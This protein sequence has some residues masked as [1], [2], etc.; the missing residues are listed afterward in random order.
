MVTKFIKDFKTELLKMNWKGGEIFAYK[1]TVENLDMED[2]CFDSTG[3][4]FCFLMLTFT[5]GRYYFS[6]F[7]FFATAP[8]TAKCKEFGFL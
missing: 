8:L 3:K 4:K 6:G 2:E 1:E 7:D 5:L